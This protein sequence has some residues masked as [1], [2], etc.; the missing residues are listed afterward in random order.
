MS[1]FRRVPWR[2]RSVNPLLDHG[3]KIGVPVIHDVAI[4]GVAFGYRRIAVPANRMDLDERSI[5]ALDPRVATGLL[6]DH[7]RIVVE[8]KVK[9]VT[10][11]VVILAGRHALE[12]LEQNFLVVQ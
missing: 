11:P 5:L 10:G 8:V 4:I 2:E 3:D 9:L 12:E 7:Q 6:M 1:R